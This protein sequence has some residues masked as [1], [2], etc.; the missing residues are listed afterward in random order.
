MKKNP[1][2]G[3]FRKNWG[4]SNRKN[5]VTGSWKNGARKAKKPLPVGNR[6]IKPGRN[7]NKNGMSCKKTQEEEKK[8]LLD[9]GNPQ[10]EVSRL[11]K[12][13]EAAAQQHKRIETLFQ[14][15]SDHREAAKAHQA[16]R[17]ALEKQQNENKKHSSRGDELVGLLARLTQ[18]WPQYASIPARRRGGGPG[19]NAP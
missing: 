1:D 7:G 4:C 8:R 12:E 17:E 11:E 19:S 18:E 16:N 2:A 14:R 13:E 6:P 5:P 15:D 9:L 10:A 3:R